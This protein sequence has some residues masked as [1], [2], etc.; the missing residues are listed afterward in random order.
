MRIFVDKNGKL[1]L[2]IYNDVPVEVII[3]RNK[4]F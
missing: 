3:Y 2:K 4:D 1:S